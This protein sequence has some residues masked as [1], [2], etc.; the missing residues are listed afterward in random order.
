MGPRERRLIR[1]LMLFAS[2]LVAIMAAAMLWTA[3]QQGAR[4]T[5]GSE[6][7]VSSGPSQG[8]SGP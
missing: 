5:P 6:S 8:A 4:P 1:R 2:V 3:L 7:G